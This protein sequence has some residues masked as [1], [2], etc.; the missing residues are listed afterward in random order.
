MLEIR[1]DPWLEDPPSLWWQQAIRR[2]R[3]DLRQ[4]RHGGID[5]KCAEGT[6]RK[7]VLRPDSRNNV[8]FR[9]KPPTFGHFALQILTLNRKISTS[10]LGK[11]VIGIFP[12]V[13]CLAFLVSIYLYSPLS[14]RYFSAR[15]ENCRRGLV[16]FVYFIRSEVGW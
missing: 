4:V 5:N 3:Q 7:K 1:S 6:C 12:H 11:T 16:Y 8:L 14:V 9:G 15:S 13:I 10:K 2:S